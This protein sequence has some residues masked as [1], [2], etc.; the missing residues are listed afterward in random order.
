[1]KITTRIATF[2][3]FA[4]LLLGAFVRAAGDDAQFGQAAVAKAITPGGKLTASITFKNTGTT[5]WTKGVYRLGA[6]N[7]HDNSIWGTN[8]VE[9]A[10]D[11]PPQGTATFSFEITAP[12]EPAT[13]NFQWRMVHE[14]VAWFGPLTPNVAIDVKP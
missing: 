7:P 9:L 1:M 10:A 14:G 3:V 13:Y 11:V 2:A 5:T 8:R 12:K 6:Q 4:V